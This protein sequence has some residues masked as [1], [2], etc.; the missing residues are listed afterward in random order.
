MLLVA[1]WKNSLRSATKTSTG[2]KM[3][4]RHEEMVQDSHPS[5]ELIVPE[6]VLHVLSYLSLHKAYLGILGYEHNLV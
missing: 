2:N 6:F 1:R 5:V 4:C 3:T